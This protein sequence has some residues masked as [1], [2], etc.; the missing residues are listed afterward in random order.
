MKWKSDEFK[1]AINMAGA[2]SAG[3]YTA[4]V[5]DFLMEALE[6]WQKAKDAL[7]AYLAEPQSASAAPPLVP[8][9]D[10]T[11]EAFSGASAGG[12]CAAIASVMVQQEFAHIRTAQETN[13]NNT[14]YEAWVNQIDIRELLKTQDVD[15]GQPLLSLLDST[16]VDTIAKTALQP[17]APKPQPYVSQSLTLLLALT[18][19]RGTPYLLYDDPSPTVDE[20][21]AYYGDKLRFETTQA[22]AA[23]TSSAAKPLPSGAPGAGAWPLLQEAAKATGAFPLFL[24]P[25]ILTRDTADYATPPWTT[26]CNAPAPGPIPPAFPVPPPATIETLN[27]DAGITNNNPFQLAHDFLAGQNPRAHDC[28][29]PRPPLEANCAV[30]TVAPFPA[31]DEFDPK[32]NPAFNAGIWRMLG[33]LVTVLVAQS[34]FLGESL[35]ALTSAP[36]FSRF[37]VAPSDPEQAGASPLQCSLLGAFGGFF[38]RGFRAHDFLLGRRNCQRFLSTHFCLPAENPVIS[39]GLNNA[40]LYSGAIANTFRLPPPNPKLAAPDYIWLPIIPCVGT[41]HEEVPAPRP[42]QI[43]ASALDEIVGLIVSRLKGVKSGLLEGAPW[44]L[45][46]LLSVALSWPVDRAVKS[47]LRSALSDALCPNVAG[48]QSSDC[49]PKGS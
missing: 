37:V 47:K 13:T 40:G 14:F 17:A 20:F 10:I 19:V 49:S 34:R 5:L 23:P 7:R 43:A 12:M 27:V 15:D 21:I 24:A 25:R 39:A 38:E 11:I 48:Q 45:K 18:N 4:G 46:T 36:S 22:G 33:R 16:I 31:T 9:H 2:V 32:Y 44:L 28:R 26:P 35:E 8:L 3:A 6:E 41:A 1:I 30:I 42:A 29:N